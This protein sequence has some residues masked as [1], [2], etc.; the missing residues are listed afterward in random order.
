MRSFKKLLD[1]C[2]VVLIGSLLIMVFGL[3]FLGATERASMPDILEPIVGTV[4]QLCVLFFS[5][6]AIVL[7]L[8]AMRELWLTRSNRPLLTNVFYFV[9]VIGFSW[10]AGLIVYRKT[11]FKLPPF[12]SGNH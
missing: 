10:I 7:W 8:Y 5:F 12:T 11:R 9:L 6:S 1:A 4:I 3:L 2:C